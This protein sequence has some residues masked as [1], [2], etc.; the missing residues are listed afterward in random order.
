MFTQC[1]VRPRLASFSQTQALSVISVLLSGAAA[2]ILA[3]AAPVYAQVITV[4]NNGVVVNGKGNS[5]EYVDRR[6]RQVK[7]TNVELPAGQMDSRTRL[8]LIRALE[9]EQGFAMR[10]IPRGHHGLVLEANGK[11]DPAG[12]KYLDMVTSSGLSAKPG[13]RVVITDIKVERSRIVLQLN[14]GPDFKHRFLRHIQIGT[15][16]MLNPVVQD[17]EQ[18]PQGARVTLS[19]H[20]HVP[21]LQA[22]Q[23]EALLA[24]LISFGVKTPVEAFT[25]TLPSSL[26]KAILDHQVLVGMSTDMVLFAKGRPE[27]KYHEMQGQMPIDIWV[28]GKPPQTVDFVHINGN[29]VIRVEIACVGKPIEVFDKDVVYGMMRTDGTPVVPSEAQQ[30]VHIVQLGD[31]QRN[32]NTQAPAP[33]PTLRTP[34]ETLPAEDSASRRVGVMRPVVFP[35]QKPDDDDSAAARSAGTTS[36]ALPAQT[37]A[38]SSETSSNGKPQVRADPSQQAPSPASSTSAP[39]PQ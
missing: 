36:P 18:T 22:K 15:G 39:Q 6:F 5:D 33:A 4:D 14:G 19:F 32:P 30:R 12:E 23:V 2:A 29:R 25:D 31:V 10:P 13:D 17:A 37:S 16:P 24:P 26:K 21:P 35:H 27:Q 8:E 20:G 28:Y 38:S 9:A 3:F 34:G 1:P 7:P 11:L